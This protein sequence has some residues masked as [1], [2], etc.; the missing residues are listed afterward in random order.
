MEDEAGR[1]GVGDGDAGDGDASG[2]AHGDGIG[3]RGADRHTGR[4]GFGDG[5]VTLDKLTVIGAGGGRANCAI[6]AG[7]SP[8]AAAAGI[9]A[10]LDRRNALSIGSACRCIGR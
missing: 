8:L 10:I 2:V 5:D 7:K 3:K 1:L 4:A 6:G 9:S